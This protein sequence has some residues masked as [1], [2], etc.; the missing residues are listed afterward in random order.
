MSGEGQGGAEHNDGMTDAPEL[1]ELEPEGVRLTR[2]FAATAEDTFDAWVEPEVMKLWMFAGDSGQIVRVE[3][4]PI[5][6]GELSILEHRNGEDVDHYGAYL[7][8]DRPTRL[9]FTLEVPWHF[10][11]V[12]EVGVD[13][14]PT[15]QGCELQFAQ[16]GVERAT[17]EGDWLAMFD[18]LEE[19]L[20]E[21]QA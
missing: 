5:V 16:D 2:R 6:G 9:A 8:L 1:P 12:T 10:E 13:I 15:A 18:R 17:T 19:V 7:E 3:N 21:R 4:D 11:G 14:T 20:R